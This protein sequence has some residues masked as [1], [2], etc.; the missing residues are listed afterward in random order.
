MM[1]VV[2]VRIILVNN[3]L[4]TWYRTDNGDMQYDMCK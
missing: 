2:V 4:I 3:T 1:I